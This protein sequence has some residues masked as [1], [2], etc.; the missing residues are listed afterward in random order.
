VGFTYPF[1]AEVV[2]S[3][4]LT[5][6]GIWEASDSKATKYPMEFVGQSCRS[7]QL[8][9]I[10][11]M[12]A[13]I[14]RPIGRFVEENKEMRF[15]ILVLG[16]LL[17]AGCGSKEQTT[18]EPTEATEELA[19]AAE[20]E[21]AAPA[22]AEAEAGAPELLAGMFSAGTPSLPT[23]FDGIELGSPLANGDG[24][25]KDLVNPDM[26]F[27]DRTIGPTHLM[28]GNYKDRK[29]LG[30]TVM[31]NTEDG[32]VRS[33]DLSLPPEGVKA[34]LESLW[35]EA[36]EQTNPKGRVSHLWTPEGAGMRVQ[37]ISVNEKRVVIKFMSA[38]IR[39]PSARPPAKPAAAAAPA[40][41]AKAE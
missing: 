40:A 7:G 41:P 6:K 10:G 8:R 33:M 19:A 17:V 21:E 34:H 20:G 15:G 37:L 30:F 16:G 18:S 1:N 13:S 35:G 31:V 14:F 29:G 24:T 28:G 27:F 25:V 36:T 9:G 11:L 5:E 4:C 26:P 38:A 23:G 22:E 3:I 2:P 32:N 12:S 39:P